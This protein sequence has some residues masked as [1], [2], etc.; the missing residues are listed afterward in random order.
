MAGISTP[1]SLQIDPP[2]LVYPRPPLSRLIPQGWYILAPHESPAS[3]LELI[4]DAQQRDDLRDLPRRTSK[5]CH[6]WHFRRYF[7]QKTLGINQKRRV[8][9]D[10]TICLP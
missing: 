8:F 4:L 1:P 3:K 2:G 5:F 10:F 7:Q 6:F 9:V